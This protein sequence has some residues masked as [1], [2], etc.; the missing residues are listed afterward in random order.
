VRGAAAHPSTQALAVLSD[1]LCARLV[2]LCKA[3]AELQEEEC[4]RSGI[5]A[6]TVGDPEAHAVAAGY[7][8]GW[9]L[10]EP[11]SLRPAAVPAPDSADRVALALMRHIG[12]HDASPLALMRLS[13][14]PLR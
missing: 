10:P 2:N 9:L 7:G 6:A 5:A 12:W 8:Q 11:A 14:A 4:R 13:A 3:L 1:A